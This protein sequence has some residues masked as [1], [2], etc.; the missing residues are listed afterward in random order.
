M[1]IEVDGPH[2]GGGRRRADDDMRDHQWRRCLLVVRRVAV[3]YTRP[4]RVDEL[5][6]YLKEIVREALFS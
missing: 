6:S 4:E 3:E 1:L 5:D 2:H